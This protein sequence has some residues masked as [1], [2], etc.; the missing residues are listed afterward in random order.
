MRFILAITLVALAVTLANAIIV[1]VVCPEDESLCVSK[2][3]DINAEEQ[4]RQ[5]CIVKD[6]KKCIQIELTQGKPCSTSKSGNH[7]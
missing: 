6:G 7:F 4:N 2:C 1:G 5:T 3:T